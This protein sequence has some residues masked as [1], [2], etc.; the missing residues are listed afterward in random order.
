MYQG[1]DPLTTSV[2][3][4]LETVYEGILA[5]LFFTAKIFQLVISLFSFPPS[6]NLASVLI[7]LLKLFFL[8]SLADFYR[9]HTTLLFFCPGFN[10]FFHVIIMYHCKLPK[11]ISETRYWSTDAPTCVTFLKSQL[12]PAFLQSSKLMYL[13]LINTRADVSLSI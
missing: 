5:I 4:R 8:M 13:L 1:L 11:I 12:M 6:Y 2:D 7:T 3:P 10:V 9:H